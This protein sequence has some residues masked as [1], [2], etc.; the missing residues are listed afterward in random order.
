MG[1][2]AVGKEQIS[3]PFPELKWGIE[4]GPCEPESYAL[5]LLLQYSDLSQSQDPSPGSNIF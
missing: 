5:S 3:S 4:S 1:L 2:I